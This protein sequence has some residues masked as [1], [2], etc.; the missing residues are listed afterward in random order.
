[1]DAPFIDGKAKATSSD[2]GKQIIQE[3]G[4]VQCLSQCGEHLA[5]HV[6]ANSRALRQL[7]D[8][9]HSK[10]TTKKYIEKINSERIEGDRRNKCAWKLKKSSDSSPPKMQSGLTNQKNQRTNHKSAY[11]IHGLLQHRDEAVASDSTRVRRH[12]HVGEVLVVNQKIKISERNLFH[13]GNRLLDLCD[14]GGG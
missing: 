13:L 12:G 3:H 6:E 8:R 1:M 4:R 9:L 11:R 7:S 14:G 5:T 2:L 10:Q